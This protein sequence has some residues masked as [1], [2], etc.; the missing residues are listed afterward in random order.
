MHTRMRCTYATQYVI[1]RVAESA[2]FKWNTGCQKDIKLQIL[3]G[4]PTIAALIV[5]GLI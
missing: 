5:R 2:Q 4:D 1:I 3:A